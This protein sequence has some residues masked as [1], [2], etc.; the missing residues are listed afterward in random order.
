[1]PDHALQSA[2]AES[3]AMSDAPV[4][5]AVEPCPLLG[6]QWETV[7]GAAPEADDDPQP[8]PAPKGA[9]DAG[10]EVLADAHDQ[11]HDEDPA[12]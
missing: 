11:Q 3:D 8:D 12:S 5:Q 9:A 6:G 7:E 2:V 1:M 10:W 4:G